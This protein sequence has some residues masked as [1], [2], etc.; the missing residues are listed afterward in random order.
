MSEPNRPMIGAYKKP[1]GSDEITGQNI[2]IADKRERQE[3]PASNLHEGIQEELKQGVEGSQ[4]T[5]EKAK[6]YEEIL[7]DN[8]IS[9][10][11][12]QLIVDAMLTDG[13][14]EETMPVT[15][16]VTVTLR[17]RGYAD[18]K[19]YLRALELYNPRFVDE[20]QEIMARHF[21]AASIVSFKGETLLHAPL[22]ATEKERED[23]FSA[24]MKWVESKSER[25]INLLISK[26]NKF[27]R[28][29]SI[30][31][32]EGVVENF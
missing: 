11:K 6:S 28:M 17:T 10:S 13:Y 19:R 29:I 25:V 4:D 21:L 23:A 7:A 30:V 26:L 22:E 20:Q 32:S 18:Y 1:G 14:Y 8:D 27:D 15:K 24:R 2:E 12:A 5:V 9:K 31:M 3:T 16:K